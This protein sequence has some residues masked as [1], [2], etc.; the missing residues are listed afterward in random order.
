MKQNVCVIQICL[1]DQTE[2]RNTS[3]N[4]FIRMLHVFALSHKSVTNESTKNGQYKIFVEQ[5]GNEVNFLRKHIILKHF[6]H[7]LKAYLILWL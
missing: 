3:V 2:L 7:P 5:Y 4:I 6:K 1:S